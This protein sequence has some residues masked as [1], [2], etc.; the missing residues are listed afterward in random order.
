VGAV[1]DAGAG[2]IDWG[3]C[4]DPTT[5]ADKVVCFS[6]ADSSL[7]LLAPGSAIVSSARGGG[8][9]GL[10]G[11]SMASPHAAGVAALLLDAV[12]G[13]TPDQVEARLKSTGVSIVDSASG[14]AACRVDA[15]NAVQNTSTGCGTT[16][17]VLCGGSAATIVGS[18]GND[19]ITGTAGKDVINGLG[20]NDTIDGL[21]GNDTICGG[22]G[23]DTLTGGTGADRLLGQGGKDSL[24][25]GNGKDNLS[26]GGGNDALLGGAGDDKMDGGQQAD[27]CDG[28]P[29]V[30]GDSAVNCETVTGVP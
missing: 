27:T 30:A 22:A 7:D 10:S 12:P 21:G 1:Y 13:L 28:G 8:A 11:T 9:A 23:N 29:H 3:V 5:A 6:N 2:A 4:T 24:D 26:G 14:L 16:V 25:G 15:L 19:T 20:G 18:A 17:A